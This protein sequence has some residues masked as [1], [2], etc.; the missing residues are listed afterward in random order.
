MRAGEEFIENKGV[1]EL[2]KLE[3]KNALFY[4]KNHTYLM[5]VHYDQEQIKINFQEDFFYEEYRK[6]KEGFGLLNLF[7]PIDGSEG[8][9][10]NVD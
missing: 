10:F 2:D 3:M 9:G 5:M 4:F 8:H 1:G 6:N 7:L